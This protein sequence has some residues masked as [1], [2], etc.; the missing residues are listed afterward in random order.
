M[1]SEVN[2]GVEVIGHEEDELA[3][4]DGGGVVATGGVEDLVAGSGMA[5]VIVIAWF[6]INGDEEGTVFGNPL[7]NGVWEGFADGAIHAGIVGGWGM[8][9]KVFLREG[10]KQAGGELVRFFHALS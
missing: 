4:P 9:G 5:E 3:V 6:A 8:W 10:A 1:V 7:R 2:D